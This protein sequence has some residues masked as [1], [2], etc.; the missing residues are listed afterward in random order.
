MNADGLR[1]IGKAYSQRNEVLVAACAASVNPLDGL[2]SGKPYSLRV[3]I[4]LRKPKV[5][6]IGIC[7]VAAGSLLSMRLAGPRRPVRK[8]RCVSCDGKEMRR[9][10]RLGDDT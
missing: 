10:M 2:A 8:C 4:G 6:R 5:T 3:M 7:L 9:W 1:R